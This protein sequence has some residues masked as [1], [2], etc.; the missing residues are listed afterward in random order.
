MRAAYFLLI[1][2][3]LDAYL[4]A[5]KTSEEALVLEGLA[6]GW[7]RL[8]TPCPGST[9]RWNLSLLHPKMEHV[10]ALPVSGT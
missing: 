3:H 6:P 5:A 9:R 4:S 1:V 10:L 8:A 7:A 2:G